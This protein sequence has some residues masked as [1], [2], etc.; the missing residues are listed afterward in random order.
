M[1]Y[2]HF[3]K[4]ILYIIFTHTKFIYRVKG[5][6]KWVF[7]VGCFVFCRVILEEYHSRW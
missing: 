7:S 3:T 4:T 5:V 1:Y 2:K 6:C